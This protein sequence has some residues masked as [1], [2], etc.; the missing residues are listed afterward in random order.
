MLFC[1]LGVCADGGLGMLHLNQ[2]ISP[3][4]TAVTALPINPPVTA[5]A[6]ILLAAAVLL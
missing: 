5:N 4:V 2:S 6:T 1:V 3:S